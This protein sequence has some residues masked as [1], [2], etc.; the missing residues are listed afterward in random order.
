MAITVR[1]VPTALTWRNF[2]EV[3]TLPDGDGE[4][5]AQINPITEN[6]QDIAIQRTP[7]G[8]LRLGDYTISVVVGRER[9][10]VLRTATKTAVLLKHEQGHHDL[11]FLAMR[12][13]ARELE[14]IEAT[15][16]DDLGHQMQETSNLHATRAATID[17]TYDRETEHGK[18]Q[19]QQARWDAAIGEA[20]RD[21]AAAHILTHPL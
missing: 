15:D 17:G 4:E 13:M 8:R 9:T 19:E 16:P 12:A 10:A 18:N 1:Q 3:D 6:R 11:F 7:S 5:V 20:K 14:A 21:A 2:R